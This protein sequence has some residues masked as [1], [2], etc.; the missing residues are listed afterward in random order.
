MNKQTNK[1]LNY[2]QRIAWNSRQPRRTALDSAAFIPIWHHLQCQ[3]WGKYFSK[4]EGV[5]EPLTTHG[6]AG[7]EMGH[8]PWNR[9]LLGSYHRSCAIPVLIFANHSHRW[10]IFDV[11]DVHAPHHKSCNSHSIPVKPWWLFYYCYGSITGDFYDR[12]FWRFSTVWTVLN[13][14]SWYNPFI[15]V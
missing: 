14:L 4:R 13:H 6:I 1:Y 11:W 3:W 5:V 7:G 15:M 2:F 12:C 9:I 8:V 10:N